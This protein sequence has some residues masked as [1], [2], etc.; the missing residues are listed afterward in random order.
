MVMLAE[1]LPIRIVPEQIDISAVRDLM[2]YSESGREAKFLEAFHA[3]RMLLK[4]PLACLL[5]SI[6]I[7]LVACW[8]VWFGWPARPMD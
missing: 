1:C 4:E 7:K 5:P 3:E 6:V 2:I 8:L